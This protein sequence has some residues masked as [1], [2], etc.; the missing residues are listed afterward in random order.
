MAD[1]NEELRV[2]VTAEVDKAIKNLK[3]VDKQTGDTEKLFKK[4]GGS[5][6]AAFSVKAISSFIKS[7]VNFFR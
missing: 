2:L 7:S 5:I 6:G 1:I 4:L 3:S